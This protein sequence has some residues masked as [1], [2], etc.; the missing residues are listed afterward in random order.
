MSGQY[1]L[2]FCLVVLAIVCFSWDVIAI[3]NN[4]PE[5]TVSWIIQQWAMTFPVFPFVLGILFGHFFWPQQP[6]EKRPQQPNE[7][8]K[9]TE[10]GPNP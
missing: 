4:A 10:I 6:I 8:Q 1:V 7:I 5:A 9:L 2:A 3:Y